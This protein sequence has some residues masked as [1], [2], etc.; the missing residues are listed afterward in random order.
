MEDNDN[1]SILS[2]MMGLGTTLGGAGLAG[3]YAYTKIKSN[4]P[5]SDIISSGSLPTG[6]VL[7]DAGQALGQS[8]KK[9]VFAE[10][11]KQSAQGKKLVEDLMQADGIQKILSKT[12]E[13]NA[14]VQSMI[15]T[16]D[17]SGGEI[18][19]ET[20]T[21]FR[22]SMDNILTNDVSVEETKKILGDAL[23][24]MHQFA[25]PET[26]RVFGREMQENRKIA[27][28]LT[29]PR[30]TLTREKP[31][32]IVDGQNLGK[33]A[34]K[35]FAGLKRNLAEQGLMDG[36]VEFE[37]LKGTNDQTYVRVYQLGRSNKRHF[38][39]TLPLDLGAG[40]NGVWSIMTGENLST[41]YTVGGFLNAKKF[42]DHQEKIKNIQTAHQYA[43]SSVED[44][45]L[46][47][48][49][50]RIVKNKRADQSAMR[51]FREW[52]GAFQQS[53]DRFAHANFQFPQLRGLSSHIDKV[54]HAG[55]NT[56][57]VTGLGALK[58]GADR[59]EFMQRLAVLPG[60]N[61]SSPDNM[62]V[63]TPYGFVGHMGRMS[64]SVLTGMG[65]SLPFKPNRSAFPV[66]SRIEQISGRNS[67][68]MGS[69]KKSAGGVFT[70]GGLTSW[71]RQGFSRVGSNADVS[72]S[73]V[74]GG[75]NRVFILHSDTK[76]KLWEVEGAGSAYG[77]GKME[78][79]DTFTKPI[80][81]PLTNTN[82]NMST[83]LLEK[84]LQR[85]AAGETLD[86]TAAELKEYDHFLGF[87]PNGKQY[88]KDDPRTLG[89]SMAAYR[90]EAYGKQQINVEVVRKRAMEVL[91]IFS[92]ASKGTTQNISREMS[93]E[94]AGYA[95]PLLGAVGVD[96][97]DVLHATPDMHKKGYGFVTKQ[98]TTA[99]GILSKDANYMQSI[100]ANMASGVGHEFAETVR[101]IIDLAA[102]GNM[103]SENAGLVLGL[104]A[105]PQADSYLYTTRTGL[106]ASHVHDMIRT[107]FG[108][109]ADE[110]LKYAAE[111]KAVQVATVTQGAG[112]GDYGAGRS[113]MEQRSYW[114]A[115]RRL[116]MM[117]MDANESA[118][119]LAS[120]YKR[121]VGVAETI[122][123][124]NALEAMSKSL[125][126]ETN[127]G[128]FIDQTKLKT[129]SLKD[130]TPIHT[131]GL[132]EFIAQ[133][134]DGFMM[135]MT[136]DPTS[137][138]QERLAAQARKVFGDQ[139]VYFAGNNARAA[140]KGTQIKQE[141]KSLLIDDQYT[142]ETEALF[143]QLQRYSIDASIPEENMVQTMGNYKSSI[144]G[145]HTAFRAKIL[146]GKHKGM[147]S[148]VAEPYFLDQGTGLTDSQRNLALALWKK[149]KGQAVFMDHKAFQATLA[150]FMGDGRGKR[151][152]EHAATLTRSFYGSSARGNA[153][154][155]RGVSSMVGRHPMMGLGNV[156][157]GAAYRDVRE[158]GS[159][160]DEA[161]S[162][163]ESSARGQEVLKNMPSIKG[164][165]DVE[166]LQ[167]K[168]QTDFWHSFTGHLLDTAHD[169][170]GSIYFPK[171]TASINYNGKSVNADLGFLQEAF[172][173]T[174]GDQ[175]HLTFFD[176]KSSR[177]IRSKLTGSGAK[178][179]QQDA[180]RYKAVNAI[181]GEEAK[182]GLK[183]M[184]G[185]LLPEEQ[186]IM[187]DAMKEYATQA[188]TGKV[189]IQLTQLRQSLLNARSGSDASRQQ[190]D[191]AIALIGNI[192]EH[193]LLKSKKLPR[194]M[195]Y[196]DMLTHAVEEMH[197]GRSEA[198]K[199]FLETTVF[200]G[201]QM[202]DGG[203]TI[204]NIQSGIPSIDTASQ[205]IAGM[206][207]NL[208]TL[209]D[210]IQNAHNTSVRKGIHTMV[211]PGQVNRMLEEGNASEAFA[212]MAAGED[213]A[214]AVLQASGDKSAN[215]GSA[216]S[217]AK[218]VTH[219]V[220]NALST[221]DSKYM[222]MVAA[223]IL[224]AAAIGSAIMQDQYSPQS[225]YLPEPPRIQDPPSVMP[226]GSGEV[227]AYATAGRVLNTP[228]TYL[229]ASNS[230]SIRGT[231]SNL[232]SAGAMGG[233]LSNAS[234]GN[235]SGSLR[236]N[237]TRRPITSNYL[238]RLTGEY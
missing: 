52:R 230:Y 6:G 217:A 65:G 195:P 114:Y 121:K 86:L 61:P 91:K 155:A 142:R 207:L 59:E 122:M 146:G 15:N 186:Q 74:S 66:L 157:F 173:D 25:S 126:G 31:Y 216:M 37:F 107:S 184:M 137:L 222:G 19:Q 192:Q 120:L 24:A 215:I 165:A 92:H 170:G 116:T 71:N 79:V 9:D 84:I 206:N 16:I 205:G 177:A 36:E 109:R 8:I 39:E 198:M 96:L 196:A 229:P 98:L 211:S 220:G 226:G 2:K 53:Q 235:L 113:S 73:I 231:L 58:T 100:K 133:H 106:A 221:M 28:Q 233:Y 69:G 35:R 102:K 103:S 188:K 33:V 49:S 223:G 160:V 20:L 224:G 45:Y 82:R 62:L 105:G 167:A 143:G 202:L 219:Q 48:F 181:I 50:R 145:L 117:G 14:L 46:Y 191:A 156:M 70:L 218:H 193:V 238:D 34:N 115:Q 44:T 55:S 197:A 7:K 162:A 194:Y 111:G 95:N 189:D 174:D 104:V 54:S 60:F 190:I 80:L 89:L 135:D 236:I 23:S 141:G 147:V 148:S 4:H 204:D 210:T 56:V 140:M 63:K 158:I 68:I 237:D 85:T 88:L 10:R 150:D 123:S 131:Q 40:K 76:S 151:D 17:S 163:F 144:G 81:D 227:D 130:V 178:S 112:H 101:S 77:S 234:R 213:M 129:Y 3:Y 169:G 38:L 134:P 171:R 139:P 132:A 209:V 166:N 41:S 21:S 97:D 199:H 43:G 90:T 127:L 185:E 110:V 47:E 161:F 32:T 168:Y 136:S 128:D 22:N 83:P 228:S 11:E 27:S 149:S 29:K 125:H 108:A 212:T 12:N 64:N 200:R 57:N 179:W 175:M 176:S 138:M 5:V 153:H 67:L 78:V 154:K 30:T 201:S 72:D 42:I 182:A 124:T 94:Y 208:G 13:Y 1:K 232:G 87:G 183:S 214:S 152:V 26:L 180:L 164:F 225:M 203:V 118:G 99:Y 172:G 51:D 75:A 119:V 187:E 159:K 93:A 18:P